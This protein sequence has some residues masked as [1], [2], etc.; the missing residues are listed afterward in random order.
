MADVIGPSGESKKGGGFWKVLALAVAALFAVS[1]FFNFF[2]VSIDSKSGGET[3]QALV[4][5]QTG[6]GDEALEEAVLPAAG[7]EIPVVWGDLGKRLTAAGVI[8]RTQF[9]AIYENR[10]GLGEEERR[11]LEDENNGNIIINKHNAGF[12]LNLLWAFGLANKSSVLEEGP[13]GDPRYGGAGN[14]ASTGGWTIAQGDA[15]DYYSKYRLAP[16]TAEQQKL[17]TKVAENIYR[18]CCDNSTAFPDCNHGMAM[19]GLLELMAA[20]GMSEEAM[21]QAALRVNAFWFPDTYLTIAKYL[22]NRGTKWSEA[23]AKEILGKN[24]SSASGYRRVL[25]EISPV[26]SGGGGGG[27]GV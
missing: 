27:C 2:D 3:S 23:P 16:L 5:A 12:W 21:Y 4:A 22:Q 11:L 8:D 9:D 14:F 13:M 10:G 1:L 7:V 15:M 17:V 20:R 19:L 25:S 6:S 26:K 18:P 24:F